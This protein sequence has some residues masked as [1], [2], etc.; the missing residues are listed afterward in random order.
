[1]AAVKRKLDRIR[2]K[3]AE[4]DRLTWEDNVVTGQ[5]NH[6]FLISTSD[7]NGDPDKFEQEADVFLGE[8]SRRKPFSE[9]V[10]L[11]YIGVPP[12]FTDLYPV[13]EEMGAR[14][15][16]NEVQRQ[17]AMPGAAAD[18]KEQYWRYTYP[19]G[20]FVRIADIEK[21]LAMRKIDGILH[22]T[23]TFCYRQI[24]DMIFRKKLPWPLLT[25]EGDKPGPVDA[26]TR[27]RL[28][29]FVDMLK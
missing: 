13:L 14:V 5:E 6:L 27:M 10:R 21:Q 22:Y 23:Q 8:I 29:T 25:L 20:A 1:V 15:V 4:I 12:I 28:E 18:I 26:R 9:Q 7:F 19:Y 16:F 2:A 17:F 11:A 3:C 24:E